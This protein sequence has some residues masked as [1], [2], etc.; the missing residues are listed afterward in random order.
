VNG[1]SWTYELGAIALNPYYKSLSILEKNK[2]KVLAEKFVDM[3]RYDNTSPI[4][5]TYD[6]DNRTLSF[7]QNGHHFYTYKNNFPENFSFGFYSIKNSTSMMINDRANYT[8]SE[9][10]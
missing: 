10:W 5:I 2:Y 1:L 8:D 7:S 4:Q 6:A 9:V 3:S